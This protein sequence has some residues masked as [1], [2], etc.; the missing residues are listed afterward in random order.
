MPVILSSQIK[1]ISSLPIKLEIV[2]LNSLSVEFRNIIDVQQT[3]LKEDD[4]LR[5]NSS[6]VDIYTLPTR[7]MRLFHG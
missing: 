2:N 3:E 5:N 6:D 1:A 4:K 7:E